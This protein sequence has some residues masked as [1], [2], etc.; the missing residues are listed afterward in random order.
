MTYPQAR[1][2][3]VVRLRNLF[4]AIQVEPAW[5]G[6]LVAGKVPTT[7]RDHMVIV[8]PSGGYADPGEAYALVTVQCWGNTIDE[9]EA[10]A[11][12]VCEF[13]YSQ[14][15]QNCPEGIS[16]ASVNGLPVPIPEPSGASVMQ[17]TLAVT[18]RHLTP[19]QPVTAGF[20]L[21][22]FGTEGF[23]L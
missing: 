6:L 15:F 3:V 7:R 23:G 10:I 22:G 20:G 11:A 18:L 12:K 14:Q 5:S 8:S 2:A 21:S 17:L 1:R 4:A 13:A 16:F 9:A 19:P